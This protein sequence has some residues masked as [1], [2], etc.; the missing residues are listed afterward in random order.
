MVIVPFA[1]QPPVLIT[2]SLTPPSLSPNTKRSIASP[3]ALRPVPLLVDAIS[4][5]SARLRMPPLLLL[6]EAS[7]LMASMFEIFGA[8]KSRLPASA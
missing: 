7:R 4:T 5:M 1:V 6:S 2:L 3:L 8:L